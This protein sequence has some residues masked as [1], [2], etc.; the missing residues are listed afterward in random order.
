MSL[1]NDQSVVGVLTISTCRFTNHIARHTIWAWSAHTCLAPSFPLGKWQKHIATC[2]FACG[3][4]PPENAGLGTVHKWSSNVLELWVVDISQNR[5]I[6][7]LKQF[8][9]CLISTLPSKLIMIPESPSHPDR[10]NVFTAE[11]LTFTLSHCLQAEGN[12]L[13]EILGE[14]KHT[15]WNA[16]VLLPHSGC[17]YKR[18][19]PETKAVVNISDSSSFSFRLLTLQNRHCICTVLCLLLWIWMQLSMAGGVTPMLPVMD[20]SLL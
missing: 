20:L 16:C 15:P 2:L 10:G 9:C 1:G 18:N 6:N 4:E 14:E 7:Y 13:I 3:R 17:V 8:W 19:N 5:H 12:S 11:V